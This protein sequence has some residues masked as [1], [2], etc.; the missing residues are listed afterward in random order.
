MSISVAITRRAEPL[1]DDCPPITLDE[2]L[3]IT[4]TLD[5][6]DMFVWYEGEID[7]KN[8]DQA[9]IARMKTLAAQLRAS[10]ISETGEIFNDDGSSAGFLPGYP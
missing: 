7:V 5:D 2:W 4:R 9:T 8:P 6:F 3:A 1:A 10:V